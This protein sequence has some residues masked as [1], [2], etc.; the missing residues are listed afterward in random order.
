MTVKRQG[1]LTLFLTLQKRSALI[2]KWEQPTHGIE[3][4]KAKQK[5]RRS[6]WQT[7][8]G[9]Q[10]PVHAH[11]PQ[12]SKSTSSHSSINFGLLHRFRGETDRRLEK[13]PRAEE[14]M[15]CPYLNK[16]GKRAFCNQLDS[17][18]LLTQWWMHRILNSLWM[19]LLNVTLW[20]SL[21]WSPHLTYVRF[22]R[23]EAC[24]DQPVTER[25]SRLESRTAD[26][27]SLV[28]TL[29]NQSWRFLLLLGVLY[30]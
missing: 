26:S 22:E 21:T 8:W 3:G 6:W 23:R 25:W 30:N 12:D 14:K 11:G 1:L 9:W 15:I 17:L 24:W 2:W 19:C 16:E 13:L 20:P 7:C 5:V 10:V 4:Q 18:L 28:L 29:N 27:R